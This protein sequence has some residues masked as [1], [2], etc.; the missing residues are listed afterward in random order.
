MKFYVSAKIKIFLCHVLLNVIDQF[1]WK[2]VIK[3]SCNSI[4]EWKFSGE[5]LVAKYDRFLEVINWSISK[6]DK[7]ELECGLHLLM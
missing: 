2:Y 4:Y 7:C 5:L 6:R 3:L 1:K